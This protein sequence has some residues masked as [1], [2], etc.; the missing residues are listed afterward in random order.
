MKMYQMVQTTIRFVS[1]KLFSKSRENKQSCYE[2]MCN[3]GL[4]F[5]LNLF[6]NKFWMF[7]RIENGHLL[8]TDATNGNDC[9]K[10]VK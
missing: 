9:T 8:L 3:W 6:E 10:L 2:Y 7:Q 4:I 1:M 5:I